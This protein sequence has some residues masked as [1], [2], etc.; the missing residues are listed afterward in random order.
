MAIV[1]YHAQRTAGEKQVWTT[2]EGLQP[3]TIY[4][5]ALDSGSTPLTDRIG[6][7]TAPRATSVDPIR[8]MAFGDS[9]GGGADQRLA[10][11]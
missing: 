11:S 3:D 2:I 7:R 9:G 10:S 5:Y 1:E 8:F 6:F 4:C